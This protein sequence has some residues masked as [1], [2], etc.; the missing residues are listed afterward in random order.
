MEDYFTWALE[1][2]IYLITK[3]SFEFC[4]HVRFNSIF[5]IAYHILYNFAMLQ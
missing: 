2:N 3:L 4:K 1:I 5:N